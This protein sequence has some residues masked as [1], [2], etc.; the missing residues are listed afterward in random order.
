MCRRCISFS[1]RSPRGERSQ[2]RPFT[3]AIYRPSEL[4]TRQLSSRAGLKTSAFHGLSAR[5]SRCFLESH[6]LA[7]EEP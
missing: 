2:L 7:N 1:R 3:L 4:T 5:K 6:S